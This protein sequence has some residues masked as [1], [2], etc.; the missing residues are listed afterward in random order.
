MV[1][2]INWLAVIVGTVA[3]MVV[4]SVWYTPKV[5]GA[6][7]EKDARVRPHKNGWL[8]IVV[9]VFTGFVTSWVLAGSAAIA[10]HFY[11][12]SFL[13]NSVITAIILWAG[14]TAVRIITHDSFENRPRRLTLITIAHELVTF[15]AI[16]LIIG[17]FGISGDGAA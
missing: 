8:P 10:H 9:G 11:G 3:T 4:G 16:A 7:W 1:P 14:L 5:F 15:L 6:I 12:G 17:L 2:E 13:A